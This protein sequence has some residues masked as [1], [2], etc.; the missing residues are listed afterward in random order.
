MPRVVLVGGRA[1]RRTPVPHGGAVEARRTLEPAQVGRVVR[2]DEVGGGRAVRGAALGRRAGDSDERQRKGAHALDRRRYAVAA[3]PLHRCGANA[4]GA[5]RPLRWAH[6]PS[7]WTTRACC[8]DGP[9]THRFVSANGTR[10]HVVE[11]GTGPLVLFLHGFPEFWWAWHQQLPPSP[12][13]ASGRSRSTCAG[14][15]RATSRRAATT[16]TRWPP[17]SPGLIRALG[18]R[19]RGARRRRL[20]RHGRLDDGRVP[21]AA[22]APARRARRGPPAAAARRRCSP[23]RAGSSP[24]SLPMLQFQVPRYEHVLTRDDAAVVGE[25]PAPLGRAGLG[26][27]AELRASTSERCREAI[28][29]PQ[30]AFCA[31]EAYRW[32]FR[33]VLRLQ[34]YRFVKQMQQPIV[35]PTLQLHG[36]LD[37]GDPA[38]HRAGLRPVRARRLRV[39]AA[40]RRRP[41]PAPGGARPGHRRDPALGEGD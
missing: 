11:A 5:D 32:A 37:T 13:P 22:G 27:R 15:A 2:G 14:T 26:R 34:G 31:L 36:A 6:E 38:A 33:S 17:T 41:L 19:P 4:A 3:R 9:W 39:A 25:L 1:E 23:T 29:I 28:R 7:R 10:F 8:V 21:P 40:R 16:A 35:S 18:E 12:T 20:R 24:P 30:A